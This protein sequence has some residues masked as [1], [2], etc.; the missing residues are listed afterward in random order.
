VVGP[1][2]AGKTT[3]LRLLT[4]ELEADAGEIVWSSDARIAIL[5]QARNAVDASLPAAQAAGGEP[6]LARTILACLGM[7]GEIGGRLVG[8]L[9]VGERTKVEIAS[10]ILQ[11][12]NVLIL[13]EPTNHLDIPSLEALEAALTRFE[14]VVIFVSHDAE[15][16]SRLAT[17]VLE[18]G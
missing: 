14:G 15:F 13:D 12:A 8:N 2:G 17:E 4:G 9:S 1:N 7:R 18:L 3:L 5:S 16:V 10:M 6:Q 11:G